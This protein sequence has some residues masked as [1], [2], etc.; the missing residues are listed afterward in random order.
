[1]KRSFAISDWFY[2]LSHNIKRNRFY[3]IIYSLLCL[4]FLVVGIAVGI[5]VNDKVAF[6]LRNSAGIF[7]FLRDDIGIVTFFFLDLLFTCIYCLFAASM[8]F[9]KALT[10]LSIMPCL[11]KSYVLGM[12]ASV[13]IVVFSVS[14]I[15]MLFVLYVPVCLIEIIILCMVSFR[16]FKFYAMNCGCS[17]SRVDVRYYY[18]ELLQYIFIIVVCALIKAI[19]LALFGSALIG[20]I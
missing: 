11:Y 6:V 8:F 2:R 12:N 15:P 5:N 17:P 14:S 19:T 3:V 4:L 18:K 9:Y 7:R 10:F 20:I 16:C 1:M 13:I